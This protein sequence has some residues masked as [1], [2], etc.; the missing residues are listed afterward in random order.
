MRHQKVGVIA[1]C[2]GSVGIFS[3]ARMRDQCSALYFAY[4]D[5]N[6]DVD[7]RL[8]QHQGQNITY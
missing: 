5:L 1:L 6:N 7:L 4:P 3:G 8:P 2:D